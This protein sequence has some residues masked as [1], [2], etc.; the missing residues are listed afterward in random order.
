MRLEWIVLTKER[1]IHCSVMI[2]N[3]LDIS[4]LQKEIYF[5]KMSSGERVLTG[6]VV[7]Q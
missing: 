1:Y 4:N 3:H 2:E 7:V 5:V 6:K